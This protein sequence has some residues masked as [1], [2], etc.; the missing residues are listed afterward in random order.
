MSRLAGHKESLGSKHGR[1]A[2]RGFSQ[3]ELAIV[4][5]VIGLLLAIGVPD[6]I[7]MIR[8]AQTRALAEGISHGLA[9]A[10]AEALRRNRDIEFVLTDLPATSGNF[11]GTT[12]SQSGRNWM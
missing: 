12:A 11:A 1:S 9:L 4:L 2:A 6:A 5:V 8:N 10:R 7:S 3:I